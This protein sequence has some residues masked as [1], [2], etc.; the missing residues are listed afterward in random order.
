MA[1]TYRL[2]TCIPAQH[3][4]ILENALAA[5]IEAPGVWARLSRAFGWSDRAPASDPR[6][7]TQDLVSGGRTDLRLRWDGAPDLVIELKVAGPPTAEQIEAYFDDHSDVA[8]I[9]AFSRALEVRAPP[10]RRFLGIATWRD[11]VGARWTDAPLEFRQ[12]CGLIEAMEVLVPRFTPSGLTGLVEGWAVRDPLVSCAFEAINAARSKFAHEGL[13]LER[14]GK[15]DE[16]VAYRRFVYWAY[17]PSAW[18]ASGTTG[19]YTGL[20]LGRPALGLLAAGVPDMVFCLYVQPGSRHAANLAEDPE[21]TAAIERWATITAPGVVRTPGKAGGPED[22]LCAR[23]SAG[24]LFEVADQQRTFVDWAEARARECVEAG[25]IAR[26]KHH[27]A[28]WSQVPA[29]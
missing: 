16:R 8:S 21:W 29:A 19:F 28:R 1:A 27:E 14:G 26:L 23:A 2:G 13:K 25:V 5:A 22:V 12:L 24:M 6:V 11:V 10:G 17:L 7:T 15:I 20:S 3:E 9:A 4:L 18:A